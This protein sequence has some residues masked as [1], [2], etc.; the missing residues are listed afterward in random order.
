[1]KKTIV[2]FLASVIG[3]IFMLVGTAYAADTQFVVT[4]IETEHDLQAVVN[5]LIVADEN[6]RTIGGN[7][8]AV[9]VTY[10]V[11]ARF[12]GFVTLGIPV[13]ILASR[14]EGDMPGRVTVKFPW[15]AAIMKTLPEVSRE[16][17][18]SAVSSEINTTLQTES[19]LSPSDSASIAI[20]IA[21]V[22]KFKHDAAMNSLGIKK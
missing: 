1:M 16:S 9:E 10:R 20:T 19:V 11:P 8:T 12:L 2:G 6:I 17:I 22:L 5:Q 7:E 14:A 4:G 15:Y 13:H 3:T 18:E 21:T